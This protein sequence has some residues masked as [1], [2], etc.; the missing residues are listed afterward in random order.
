MEEGIEDTREEREAE[1]NYI[2][3]GGG[4]GGGGWEEGVGEEGEFVQRG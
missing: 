2:G 3:G 4:G 1:G